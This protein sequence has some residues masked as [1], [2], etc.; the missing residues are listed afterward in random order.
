MRMDADQQVISNLESEVSSLR[1]QLQYSIPLPQPRDLGPLSGPPRAGPPPLPPGLA[2]TYQPSESNQ[3]QS[4]TIPTS[5]EE[6]TFDVDQAP[7]TDF[8]SWQFGPY[9]SY[10]QSVESKL[11]STMTQLDGR[12]SMLLLNELIPIKEQLA[13]IRS[14]VGIVGMHTSW[15]MNIQ[16]ELRQ[17]QRWPQ[18]R[19]PQHPMSGAYSPTTPSSPATD[20]TSSTSRETS[21]VLLNRARPVAH[22]PSS[23]IASLPSRR[24]SAEIPRL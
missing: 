21:P 16:L 9:T 8:S 12:L 4:P 11:Q 14:S 18:H 20:A 5:S 7:E 10:I 15:L 24:S 2:F 3:A 6:D 23:D 17:R 1:K 13:E 19:W 22:D